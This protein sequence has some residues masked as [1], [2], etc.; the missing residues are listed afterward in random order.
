MKKLTSAQILFTSLFLAL[1]FAAACNTSTNTK[2]KELALN[3]EEETKSS[4]IELPKNRFLKISRN[5]GT[6]EMRK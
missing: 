6:L 4:T 2:E 5:I 1:L 3:D